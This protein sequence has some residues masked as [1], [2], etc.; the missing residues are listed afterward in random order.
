M[1]KRLWKTLALR[2]R[3]EAEFQVTGIRMTNFRISNEFIRRTTH[4]R[5]SGE[6]AREAKLR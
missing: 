3:E 4:L 6:Q 2:K 1:E 5:C